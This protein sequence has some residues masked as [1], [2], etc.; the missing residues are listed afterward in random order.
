MDVGHPSPGVMDQP[1]V[2]SLVFSHDREGMCYE[3][4]T[5]VQPPRLE[6]IENL[7]SMVGVSE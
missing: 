7:G 6:I 3:A 4:L 2:A 1:S 5:S